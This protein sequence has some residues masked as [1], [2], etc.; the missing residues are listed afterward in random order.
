MTHYNACCVIACVVIL[1]LPG[2]FP[3][4]NDFPDV[5][6]IGVNLDNQGSTLL[7]GF[8]AKDSCFNCTVWCVAISFDRPDML[9]LVKELGPFTWMMWR[10]VVQRSRYTS[11]HLMESAI[12]T[13]TIM[14]M[15]E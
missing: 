8:F 14:R 10:V 12:T 6:S 2:F 13:A 5:L 7:N 3:Y 1:F 15:L 9:S 11:A 4:L